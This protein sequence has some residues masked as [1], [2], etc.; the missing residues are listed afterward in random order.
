LRNTTLYVAQLK[1][2]GHAL[3]AVGACGKWAALGRAEM[4]GQLGPLF[5]LYIYII[6]EKRKEGIGAATI[7]HD[8]MHH[9]SPLRTPPKL[10]LGNIGGDIAHARRAKGKG[11]LARP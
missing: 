9:R 6:M 7:A 2:K 5:L 10:L 1:I 11:P 8:V 4:D 3:M